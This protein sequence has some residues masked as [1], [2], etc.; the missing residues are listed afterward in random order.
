MVSYCE[1]ITISLIRKLLTSTG[2]GYG[3]NFIGGTGEGQSDAAWLVPICIQLLPSTILAVGM[4]AFMPQSPRHLMNRDREEECLQTLARLRNTSVDD[5]RVRIEFLEIKALR[6]FERI[7]VQEK[8]PQ[9]QDGSFKSGF[10][11]Q[12]NDYLSL[13][14]NK[15]LFRRT[16][17][18]VLTM[19]F[20]Q[21]NG[22]CLSFLSFHFFPY[23]FCNTL[24]MTTAG[25]RN[26]L[27]RPLHLPRP[28]SRRKHRLAARHR[29][30]RHRHVPRDNPRR[31]LGRQ[32]R[33]QDDP[34]RRRD[35]DGVVAFHCR[36]HHG[37]IQRAVG[38]TSRG[39]LGGRRV[40]LDLCDL[41]WVLVGPCGLDY[42]Q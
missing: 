37:L 17:V 23:S 41:V 21:W 26:P 31:A 10:M 27:L 12:Y 32:L 11:I 33:T 4:V 3:T 36:R 15:A 29:R 34:H 6:D 28:R 30:R 2:I 25:Q 1:Y 39:G 35:R 14:T 16:V 8:F 13:V 38:D 18:A 40:C 19:V 20:Q 7:R 22:V 5:I 9:Y 42:Y 24:L